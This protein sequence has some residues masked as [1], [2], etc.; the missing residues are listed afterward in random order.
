MKTGD[1]EKRFGVSGTTIRRWIEAFGDFLTDDAKKVEMRQRR[2]TE[3]DYIVLATINSFSK[4]GFPFAHI[5]EK[6]SEGYRIDDPTAA[7]V[8]YTDGRLVPA[9]AVEQIIDSVEIRVELEQVKAERDKLL[10][11][12]DNYR[13]ENKELRGEVKDWQKQVI[14]L[15]REIGRLEGR[16]EEIDRNRKPKEGE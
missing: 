11:L 5:K 6:L 15:Q 7:T 16:L 13:Q 12:A 14:E 4:T 10:E 9:A 3:E 1:L 2:F 8:G